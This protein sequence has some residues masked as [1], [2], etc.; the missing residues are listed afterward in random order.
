[1][2][3]RESKILDEIQEEYKNFNASSKTLQQY[4]NRVIVEAQESQNSKIIY[5][6]DKEINGNP[7]FMVKN[8]RKKLHIKMET[9]RSTIKKPD[10]NGYQRHLYDVRKNLSGNR[11][12][13]PSEF[14]R[15]IGN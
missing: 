3:I 6:T 13:R 12:Q 1:M 4:F 14:P 5:I 8:K 15:N 11:H 10:Q 9:C 2:L 7:I